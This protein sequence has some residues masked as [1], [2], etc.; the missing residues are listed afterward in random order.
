MSY[1]AGDTEILSQKRLNDNNWSWLEN[2]NQG[3]MP[4]LIHVYPLIFVI[5]CVITLSK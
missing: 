1:S 2:F 5:N 4:I 3:C